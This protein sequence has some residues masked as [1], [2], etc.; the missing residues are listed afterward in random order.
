[1]IAVVFFS[2]QALGA[3]AEEFR[4]LDIGAGKSI[5]SHNHIEYG[6]ENDKYYARMT[7]AYPFKKGEVFAI[8]G[9][10]YFVGELNRTTQ[11]KYTLYAQNGTKTEYST[12][13]KKGGWYGYAYIENKLAEDCYVQITDFG[14]PYGLLSDDVV[15][16]VEMRREASTSSKSFDGLSSYVSSK[17]YYSN[18]EY[19]YVVSNDILL[20]KDDLLANIYSVDN[21]IIVNNVI[22]EEWNYEQ[23]VGDYYADI[24]STDGFNN[25]SVYRLN[26]KVYDKRL[27]TII[28]P[29]NVDIR[30]SEASIF[31]IS[32]ICDLY[33]GDYYNSKFTISISENEMNKI[34]NA[35]GNGGTVSVQIQCLFESG[36]SAQK[37]INV[38][39]LDD[40][41]PE[42]FIKKVVYLTSDLNNMTADEI[43]LMIEN[44][45]KAQQVIATNV[46]LL[47]S[48]MI[49]TNEGDYDLGF[50][51]E[52]NGS[53]KQGVL[54][55]RVL[56]NNPL[57]LSSKITINITDYVEQF[58]SNNIIK[59]IEDKLFSNGI[60][61]RDIRIDQSN[62]PTKEGEYD[63]SF[64]YVSQGSQQTGELHLSLVNEEK[65]N[66]YI[67]LYIIL[68]SVV[69]ISIGAYILIRRRK[70][71]V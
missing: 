71:H 32:D 6:I 70:R 29:E 7:G 67:Y 40:V 62:I 21:G 58:D 11:V 15:G 9:S 57:E 54:K 38:N 59:I 36:V 22:V 10:Q 63:L 52:E 30:M 12:V 27:P 66:E 8:Y 45:L 23:K 60:E 19:T 39:I 56:E 20:T 41:K 3:S 65:E 25:Y 24:K 50:S 13:W 61:A 42:I 4:K 55:L 33:S 47:D 51:Y 35:F 34:Y 49:P 37:M 43:A 18:D 14:V 68:G 48:S 69:V 26:I 17:D 1:M 16:E 2:F 28:G 31:D 53:T 5:L 64:T 44:S 46:C